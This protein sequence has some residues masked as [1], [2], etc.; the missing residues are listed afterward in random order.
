MLNRTEYYLN[1]IQEE[2]SEVAQ[3]ASKSIRFGLDE[4]K[5]GRMKDN[6]TLLCEE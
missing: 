3:R 6:K 4:L 1:L 5:E 2:C